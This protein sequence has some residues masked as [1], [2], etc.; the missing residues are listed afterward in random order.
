VSDG[1]LVRREVTLSAGGNYL[2]APASDDYCF[3]L[4]T[5]FYGRN[6][7]PQ[8]KQHLPAGQ[9]FWSLPTHI[10]AWFGKNPDPGADRVSTGGEM[11]ALRQDRCERVV[12]RTSLVP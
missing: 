10:D 8:H 11:T 5:D 12:E 9:Q 1:V 2:F 6:A 3:W 7:R 4:E